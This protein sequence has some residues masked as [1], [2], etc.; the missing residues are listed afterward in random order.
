M[1][2]FILFVS[3]YDNHSTDTSLFSGEYEEPAI[4]NKEHTR[5]TFSLHVDKGNI[6]L[7]P[8]SKVNL[9]SCLMRS[10][11]INPFRPSPW[12]REKINLN[13]YVHA[14]FW[15]LKRFYESFESLHKTF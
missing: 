10:L 6:A 5:M 1:L 11:L 14:S 15:C 12:R 2:I 7:F 3:G 8:P 4:P 9:L 13:L